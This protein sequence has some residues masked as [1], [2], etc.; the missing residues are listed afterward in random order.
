[1]GS[2]VWVVTELYYPEDTST[3]HLL[4]KIAEGLARRFPVRVLCSQPTYAMRG[5]FAAARETRDGVVIERCPST[6]L[7]KNYMP[8]RAVNAATISLSLFAHMVAK[9]R[10]GDVVLAVTNPPFLPILAALASRLRAAR[11]ILL[12]HDVYPEALVAS[13]VAENGALATRLFDRVTRF[14]YRTASRVIVLGRDMRRLVSSKTGSEIVIIPNWADLDEIRPTVRASNQILSRLGIAAKF[15][16]QYAGNMGRTHDLDS[17]IEAVTLLRDR[18]DIHFLLA[19]SGARQAWIE[20]EVR[21]RRLSNATVLERQPRERLNELLNACDLS[22]ISFQPGMAGVSVPCRMYNVLAAGKPILAVADQESELALVV[23]EENVGWVVP[24]GEP[25]QIANAVREARDD[26][27]QTRAKGARARAVAK[28]KYSVER[29][30]DLYVR[31][32]EEAMRPP[33]S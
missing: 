10:S 3:G 17:L 4:T 1:M 2:T 11:L 28:G 8:F 29:S 9:A 12:V 24:P 20:E 30:T 27:E 25:R 21:R 13:G 22:V 14:S 26:V 6:T 18:E 32:V 15:V 23:R 7:D 16:V 5:T 33:R 31:L 19:G